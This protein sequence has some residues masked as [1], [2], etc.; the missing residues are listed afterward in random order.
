MAGAA[1]GRA[2]ETGAGTAV[3]AAAGT[4]AR[5]AAGAAA[6][7]AGSRGWLPR[8]CVRE[9][10]QQPTVGSTAWKGGGGGVWWQGREAMEGEGDGESL[11]DEEK[12]QE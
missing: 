11:K 4:A 8:E 12:T 6:G 7:T 10:V 5:A 3:G 9:E 2:A 1:T